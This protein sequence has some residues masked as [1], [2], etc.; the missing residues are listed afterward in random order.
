MATKH[1]TFIRKFG[2]MA[3]LITV[4]DWDDFKELERYSEKPDPDFLVS[5]MTTK[6]IYSN[7]LPN[8]I[9]NI[10]EGT[11]DIT[12]GTKGMGLAGV[13]TEGIELD[14]KNPEKT[15]HLEDIAG[16]IWAYKNC[17][18][19]YSEAESRPKINEHA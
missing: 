8:I 12:E 5:S 2:K 10:G 15:R 7:M 13:I 4:T 1:N 19:T 18:L 16:G 9:V 3:V 14:Y 17:G 6:S 11:R